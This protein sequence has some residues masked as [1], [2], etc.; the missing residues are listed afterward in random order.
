MRYPV[1]AVNAKRDAVALELDAVDEAAAR[2]TARRR[3]LSVLAIHGLGLRR[4]G[5]FPRPT[6]FSQFRPR[7]APYRCP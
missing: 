1:K 5:G 4:L 7:V 6:A 3:G 2:D